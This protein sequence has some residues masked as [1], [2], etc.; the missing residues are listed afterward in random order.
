VELLVKVYLVTEKLIQQ[1]RDAVCESLLKRLGAVLDLM[2]ALTMA[3]RCPSMKRGTAMIV[4]YRWKGK[5]GKCV[6]LE[7]TCA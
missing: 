7:K 3:G 5:Y 1:F 6:C 4:P 2:D